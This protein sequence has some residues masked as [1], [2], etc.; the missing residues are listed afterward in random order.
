VRESA[1]TF[2]GLPVA[3]ITECLGSLL[4]RQLAIGLPRTYPIRGRRRA[5]GTDCRHLIDGLVKK[6]P[7]QP[8]DGKPAAGGGRVWAHDCKTRGENSPPAM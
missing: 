8:T 4:F 2:P 7:E 5:R 1:I 6:G 3:G